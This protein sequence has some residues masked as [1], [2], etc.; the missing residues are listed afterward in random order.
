M[1]ILGALFGFAVLAVVLVIWYRAYKSIKGTDASLFTKARPPGPKSN[2]LDEFISAYKRGEIGP[3]IASSPTPPLKAPISAPTIAS[4]TPAVG[5]GTA[6]ANAQTIPTKRDA[7]VS[8]STKLAYLACKSGLRDHHIFAH[9]PLSALSEGGAVD[10]SLARASVDL[11]I[12][13]ASLSAVAAVDLI[14]SANGPADATK[15]EYLRSL[16]I[17]YLRLSP[18]SLPRPDGW[19]ALLYKM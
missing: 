17:R 15:A 7:F 12:C 9:V 4:Q 8:G 14:E 13:N 3:G 16:G 1:K 5:A 18:K 11:L 2:S 6:A 10:A 19:H